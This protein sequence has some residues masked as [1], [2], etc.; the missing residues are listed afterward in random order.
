MNNPVQGVDQE[1]D[2]KL[3]GIFRIVEIVVSFI[4]IVL[5]IPAI[6]G[7]Y[8]VKTRYF[9]VLTKKQR[10]IV[11]TSFIMNIIMVVLYFFCL[12]L[13]SLNTQVI[14][15]IRPFIHTLF[16]LTVLYTVITPLI[17]FGMGN[18]D[19]TLFENI[20]DNIRS[21][22]IPEK[23]Y[24]LIKYSLYINYVYLVLVATII[25]INGGRLF[26]SQSQ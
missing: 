19:T 21:Q 11:T 5:S 8:R 3:D 1:F 9:R 6:I 13:A 12:V 7:M 4:L 2:T 10:E 17:V 24:D 22:G 20:R 23:D 18:F 14:R 26:F 16:I 25:V 15:Q